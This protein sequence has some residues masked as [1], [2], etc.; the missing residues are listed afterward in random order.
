MGID[1]DHVP[2]PADRSE[3]EEIVRQ[4]RRPPRIPTP[5]GQGD[6]DYELTPTRRFFGKER[7][8]ALSPIWE[9]ERRASTQPHGC[10]NGG[11][12]SYGAV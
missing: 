7:P 12:V 1:S 6:K 9:G 4:T 10:R 5:H 2:V 11:V 8:R 3:I